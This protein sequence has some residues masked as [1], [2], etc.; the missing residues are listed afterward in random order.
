MRFVVFT[1]GC[2]V[3]IYEGQAMISRLESKGHS[4]GDKLVPADCYIINTCSVTGEADRK[5]RQ[6]VSRIKKINP[7]A[8]IYVC[9]C[10]SQN[11]AKVYLEKNGVELVCGTSGKMEFVDKILEDLCLKTER[12]A[13]ESSVVSP[14]EFYEDDLF[15]AHTRT[16][17]LIKIQDGCNNFCSYCIVPYLRGRS[18]SRSVDS[19]VAEAEISA[20][21]SRE[22][23]L[24]GVNIS[25]FG[26]DTGESLTG[27]IRALGSVNARKRLGSLECSVI[28]RELLGAMA[29]NGF[30]PHFHLSM[31]SGSATVLKRMNRHYTPEQFLEKVNLIREIM[32]Y[33]GIT[34]DIIAGFPAETESEHC[35]TLETL[36]KIR[37]SD[38]HVFP[39][40]E[41]AGTKAANLPQVDKSVRVRRAAEIS[42]VRDKHKLEF[43]KKNIGTVREVYLEE[44]VGELSVGYTDN[45]IKVYSDA[46][47]KTCVPLELKEIYKEGLKGE[48]IYE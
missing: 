15:P 44:S 23:V 48:K 9:G 41:R 27:L 18:R 29:E 46:N 16:R 28:S 31:Q 42:A 5:S 22:I 2:K 1:L 47:V 3:N 37:F 25:A 26:K 10:S 24:T 7:N 6:T 19:I 12:V 33:A 45:Y 43:L 39:Y 17:G 40:S 36:E 11:D 20:G 14:P 13:T 34:T 21:I 35:E 4:A 30:C 8:P 38:V 32:P